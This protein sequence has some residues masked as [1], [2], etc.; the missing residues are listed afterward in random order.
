[1]KK[2]ASLLF[3]L[4]LSAMMFVLLLGFLAVILDLIGVINTTEHTLK[5]RTFL[6]LVSL[7]LSLFLSHSIVY[8]IIPKLRARDKRE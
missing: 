5:S 1:M 2:F 7:A 6:A 3:F 4:A 8:K